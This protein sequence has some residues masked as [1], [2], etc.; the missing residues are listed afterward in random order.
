MTNPLRKEVSVHHR[1]GNWAKFSLHGVVL[2][3][4]LGSTILGHNLTSRPAAHEEVGQTMSLSN[5]FHR[6]RRHAVRNGDW[7]Y[8]YARRSRSRP[9]VLENPDAEEIEVTD[10]TH[11]L[12]GQ[13][14]VIHS[15]SQPPTRAACVHVVYQETMILRIPLAATNRQRCLQRRTRTKWTAEAIAGVLTKKKRRL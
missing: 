2:R 13:R 10:P 3:A 12:F 8:A 14:F 1:F 9:V 4:D 15:L 6:M 5:A 11:P 7:R